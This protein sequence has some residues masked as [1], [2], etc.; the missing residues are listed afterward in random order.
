MANVGVPELLVIVAVLATSLV[1]MWPAGRVCRRA[2]FSAW[3]GVLV[4]VPVANVLLLWFIALA[5]WPSS[6]S[7]LDAR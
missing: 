2:G 3:L 7:T 6:R 5:D 1:V 4:M